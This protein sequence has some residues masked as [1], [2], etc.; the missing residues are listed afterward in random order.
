MSDATG[1]S[2]TPKAG[3]QSS[4]LYVT[5][6]AMAQMAI[7]A[8]PDQYKAVIVAMGGVYVAARTLLK[9]VHAAGYAK[10]V[11]DLPQLPAGTVQTTVTQVPKT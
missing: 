1:A 11:P 7:P 6:V 10:Q 2:A 4:E 3:W 8:L 5:L 9:C